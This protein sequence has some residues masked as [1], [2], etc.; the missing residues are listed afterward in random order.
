MSVSYFKGSDGLAQS[1]FKS[2]LI[3]ILTLS[4]YS[5]RSSVLIEFMAGVECGFRGGIL[6]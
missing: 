2:S 6:D 4:F 5:L 3:S 1:P